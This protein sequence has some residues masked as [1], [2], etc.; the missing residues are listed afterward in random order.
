MSVN[1]FMVFLF[2]LINLAQFHCDASL[3]EHPLPQVCPL[4]L[5][6]NSHTSK[7]VASGWLFPGNVP[8]CEKHRWENVQN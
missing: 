3:P 7:G 2:L 4:C 6:S 1:S 8:A 5:E